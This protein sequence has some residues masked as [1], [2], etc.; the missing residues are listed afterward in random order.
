MTES[1]SLR[2]TVDGKLPPVLLSNVLEE[3][4]M[5]LAFGVA[6]DWRRRG[7]WRIVWRLPLCEPH[8]SPLASGGEAWKWKRA[9]SKANHGL[10]YWLS[11]QIDGCCGQTSWLVALEAEDVVQV[12]MRNIFSI[13]SPA[14]TK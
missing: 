12:H 6:W 9:H 10:Y 1:N 3:R 11:G 5:S 13:P 8:Q 4:Q 7:G 14:K 2:A